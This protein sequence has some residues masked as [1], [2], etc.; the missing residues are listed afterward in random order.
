M[1]TVRGRRRSRAGDAPGCGGDNVKRASMSRAFS[2]SCGS[3]RTSY[4][5]ATSCMV[6]LKS[7]V[8]RA[9]AY[10]MAEVI[11]PKMTPAITP[12]ISDAHGLGL[13]KP[14]TRPMKMPS[15][16]PVITPP[17]STLGQLN[18]PVTRSTCIRSTPT[19]VTCCTGNCWSDRKS[20]AFCASAYVGY[21]PIGHPFG[22]VGR[23]T[24]PRRAAAAPPGAAPGFWPGANG[25][26]IGLI[27]LVVRAGRTCP[28]AR[29]VDR[30]SSDQRGTA[31]VGARGRTHG[32]PATRHQ[33]I[34]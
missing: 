22:G 13:K 9:I 6:E 32:E 33:H 12:V 30:S 17:P 14:S 11:S 18:R 16:A 34:R 29:A 24:G 7:L 2:A 20:T 31:G 26:V 4:R 21:E 19:I 25:L 3:H 27:L 10:G 23:A 1:R 28:P 15:Q 8:P 5:P